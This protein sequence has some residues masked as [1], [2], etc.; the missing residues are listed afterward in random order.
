GRR[1]AGRV[2]PSPRSNQGPPARPADQSEGQVVGPSPGHR[3]GPGGLRALRN[4]GGVPERALLR[5][6]VHLALLLA[7]PDQQLSGS[8]TICRGLLVEVVARPADPS[9]PTG[10]PADLLLLPQGLLPLVLVG[11]ARMRGHGRPGRV[12]RRDPLPADPAEPAPV[13]LLPGVAV[14]DHPYLRRRPCLLLPRR[15]RHG[16]RH[17]GADRERRPA[18]AVHAVLPCVPAP[19]G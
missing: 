8:R 10:L 7:V 16:A 15:V 2:R 5:R 11:A 12:P 6:P 9:V 17:T 18:L 1:S 14:P 13:H 19:G 4:L 3:P